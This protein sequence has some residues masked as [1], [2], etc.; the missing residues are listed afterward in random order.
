MLIREFNEHIQGR[1]DAMIVADG[2]RRLQ[3]DVDEYQTWAKAN[4]DDFNRY[5]VAKSR[6]DDA[7]AN[8]GRGADGAKGQ[9]QPAAIRTDVDPDE[10]REIL[11]RVSQLPAS[12][13]ARIRELLS[14]GFY[15]RSRE[16][17]ARMRRDVDREMLGSTPPRRRSGAQK[18]RRGRA[19]AAAGARSGGGGNGPV[20]QV[21]DFDAAMGSYL[22]G[23]DV[24][25]G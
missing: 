22:D 25:F 21:D 24:D 9:R 23:N 2:D 16:G 10:E 5:I 1:D 6:L 8:Q 17:L 7:R 14:Q 20:P 18:Q 12:A 19:P 13:S 4:P 3:D 15:P 11:T